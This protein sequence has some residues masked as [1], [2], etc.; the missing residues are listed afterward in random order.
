MG[1]AG[2]GGGSQAQNLHR[3]HQQL[4]RRRRCHRTRGDAGSRRG[5]SFR[6]RRAH[7]HDPNRPE[8]ESVDTK[9]PVP[10]ESIVLPRPRVHRHGLFDPSSL[11][12]FRGRPDGPP[13]HRGG[14]HQ[15]PDQDRGDGNVPVAE[16]IPGRRGHGPRRHP[17]GLLR[18]PLLRARRRKDRPGARHGRLPVDPPGAGDQRPRQGR[19]VAGKD[20]GTPAVDAVL[21]GL[22]HR[23]A[24]AQLEE[25]CEVREGLGLARAQRHGTSSGVAGPHQGGERLR[26]ALLFHEAAGGDRKGASDRERVPPEPLLPRVQPETRVRL[27]AEVLRVPEDV[28]L[29]A[30][31]PALDVEDPQA[32]LRKQ[33]EGRADRRAVQAG[34]V[35]IHGRRV[36]PDEGHAHHPVSRDVRLRLLQGPHDRGVVRRADGPARLFRIDRDDD[37]RRERRRL[38]QQ[39][40]DVGVGLFVGNLRI[41]AAVGKDGIDTNGVK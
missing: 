10:E 35:G 17:P 31:V 19:T 13:A 27:F 4:Q 3:P 29:F 40:D 36:P 33:V 14:V 41:D 20:R 15:L 39:H 5:D 2:F 34:R 9:T 30:G 23:P 22:L 12:V 25:G 28:V 32:R 11:E 8:G 1:E 37:G 38:R 16:G 18:D 6:G 24:A 7:V 21:P 26:A